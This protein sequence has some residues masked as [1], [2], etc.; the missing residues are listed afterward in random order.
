M[1]EVLENASEYQRRSQDPDESEHFVR[2]EWLDT[3]PESEAEWEVR[4]FE[5]QNAVCRP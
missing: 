3:K 5:N 2:V 1:L 4:F